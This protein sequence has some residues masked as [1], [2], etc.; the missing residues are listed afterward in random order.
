LLQEKPLLQAAEAVPAEVPHAEALP[1]E[2]PPAQVQLLQ[3]ELL[4]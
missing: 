4:Q 3:E 2:V 1:A